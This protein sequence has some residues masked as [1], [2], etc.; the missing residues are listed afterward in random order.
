[1]PSHGDPTNASMPQLPSTPEIMSLGSVTKLV[2][3]VN[4]HKTVKSG[5]IAA[6]LAAFLHRPGFDLS[7]HLHLDS[8]LFRRAQNASKATP[9]A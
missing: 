2:L 1:M 5:F 4:T 8:W 9:A 3:F 6:S 7:V